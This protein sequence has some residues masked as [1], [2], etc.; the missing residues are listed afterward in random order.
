MTSLPLPTDRRSHRRYT[1]AAAMRYRAASGPL[2]APWK[3]GQTLNMSAGGVLIRV[4]EM[5]AA[6]TRLQV[7]MDWTGLY[8]GRQAMR[9]ILTAAV[10]RVDPEGTGLRILSHRFSDVS[11][12]RVRLQRTET[13]LAVA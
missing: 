13:N 3:P 11:P 4:P 12:V 7:A 10:T 6:G 9:L 5:L 1:L 2:N 8:H